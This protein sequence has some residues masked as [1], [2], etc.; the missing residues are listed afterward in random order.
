MSD[1]SFNELQSASEE[2]QVTG[3]P[4]GDH[5]MWQENNP[6]FENDHFQVDNSPH[7]EENVHLPSDAYGHG[8]NVIMESQDIFRDERNASG[9][10]P[11][12]DDNSMDSGAID[13][14]LMIVIK[15]MGQEFL[16]K[17]QELAQKQKDLDLLTENIALSKHELE[18]KQNMLEMA[19]MEVLTEQDNYDSIQKK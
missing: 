18:E 5:R 10:M 13:P 4:I 19:K 17:Q 1:Q 3:R 8:R 12:E 6:S 16:E 7:P 15:E 2:Q 9:A 11:S 14:E